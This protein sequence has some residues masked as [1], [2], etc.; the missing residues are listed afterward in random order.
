[1]MKKFFLLAIMFLGVAL[2]GAAQTGDVPA[3]DNPV[4]GAFTT[5]AMLVAVI[6]V[7]T[8]FVKKLLPGE[9]G[10]GFWMQALSWS[11]GVMVTV[12]G[13][14]LNLGF[15]SGLSIWM[16]LLYGLGASLAANGVFDTHIITALF[17]LFTSKNSDGNEKP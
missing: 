9:N 2:Y 7:V 6:P 5:F 11:V 15:L 12:F 8:E 13:W 17:D 14:L 1:M 3:T 16:A 4:A 10:S